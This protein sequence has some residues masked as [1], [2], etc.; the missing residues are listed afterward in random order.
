VPRRALIFEASVGRDVF[1]N[2]GCA[3]C[4][5]PTLYTGPSDVAALA[6]RAFSLFSDFLLHDMGSLNDGVA[7]GD[8]KPN[9]IGTQPLW[10]LRLVTKY[11]HDG[12]AS[13]LE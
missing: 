4:H 1:F 6:F 2:V 12:R 11:L 3:D 5:T 7:Q 13:T 8:A 9:E 10:G